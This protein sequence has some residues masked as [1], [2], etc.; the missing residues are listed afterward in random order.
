MLRCD[1][2]T[3]VLVLRI[4]SHERACLLVLGVSSLDLGR[5]Q[6]R[7]LFLGIALPFPRIAARQA[8]EC[9]DAC[10]CGHNSVCALARLTQGEWSAQSRRKAALPPPPSE[11]GTREA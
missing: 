8:T 9:I 6:E 5:S 2:W 7:P 11:A 4:S 10:L 1:I 3:R